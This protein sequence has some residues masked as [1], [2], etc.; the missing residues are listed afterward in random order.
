MLG[1]FNPTLGQ[2]WTNPAVGL[3]F[4]IKF[5]TQKLGKS[6][7]DPKLGWN[8]PAFFRVYILYIKNACSECNPD[9]DYYICHVFFPQAVSHL[10][11][12]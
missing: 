10:N 4:Y 1:C 9:V 8:N 6:I 2:I 3:N 5:L 7:F 11:N 12:T